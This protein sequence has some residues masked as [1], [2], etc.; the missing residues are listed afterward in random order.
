MCSSMP[1]EIALVLSLFLERS[2][3]G[4]WESEDSSWLF[5][6]YKLPSSSGNQPKDSSYAK[7]AQ[8]KRGVENS[9]CL[10]FS[11][12]FSKLLILVCC[13][14][15]QRRD[16]LCFAISYTDTSLILWVS[17]LRDIMVYVWEELNVDFLL[18]H[19]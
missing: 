3:D 12:I 4:W 13:L 7:K 19:H 2:E 5:L 16:G 1:E 9:R 14:I 11:W 8:S 17:R 15:S 18:K 6:S 10:N